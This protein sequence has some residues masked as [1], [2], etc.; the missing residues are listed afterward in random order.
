MPK[1]TTQTE[2]QKA[3]A[4]K[5]K[6]EKFAE[7]A[8]KRL[9][10]A[11]KALRALGNLANYSPSDAQKEFVMKQIQEALTELSAA[12]A[13]KKAASTAIAVPTE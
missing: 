2:E 9:P 3:A 8:G 5:V 13:G 10:V 6:R 12:Y 11:Q 4:L 7:L 1:G